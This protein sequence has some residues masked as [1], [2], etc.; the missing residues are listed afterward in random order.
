MKYGQ[1]NERTRRPEGKLSHQ[2]VG[3]GEHCE[4]EYVSIPLCFAV[5][6]LGV[7]ECEAGREGRGVLDLRLLCP[8]LSSKTQN[9]SR[10]PTHSSDKTALTLPALCPLHKRINWTGLRD[11]T[12]ITLLAD[13]GQ[14][15]KL[16]FPPANSKVTPVLKNT[17]NFIMHNSH[18]FP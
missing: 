18:K 17:E 7:G 13:M 2:M 6:R 11:L 3:T 15:L 14:C 10:P 9:A 16:S 5:L 12:T 8:A 1:K 4:S